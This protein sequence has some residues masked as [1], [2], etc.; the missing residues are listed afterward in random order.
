MN[1]CLSHGLPSGRLGFA[2]DVPNGKTSLDEGHGFSRAV[3]A[4]IARRLQPLRYGF[5]EVNRPRDV[6]LDTQLHESLRKNV[7]QGLNRLRK[8]VE[9][10]AKT[11]TLS[12]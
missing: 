3:K 4:L 12:G 5:Q 9:Q 10:R 1:A 8:N 11:V 2:L 6:A 7:P